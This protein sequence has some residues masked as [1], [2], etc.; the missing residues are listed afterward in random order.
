ML[1]FLDVLF[2]LVHLII[3]GFNLLGW[4]WPVTRKTH[5]IC[6]LTTVVS[7]F[8]LG[9]WFGMGYCPVTDWQWNVK[10]KLGEINLPAS[11]VKYYADKLFQKNFSS[12]VIDTL[13]VVLFTISALFA[14]YFN[15]IYK[16][17]KIKKS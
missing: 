6:V 10:T 16:K 2:T 12:S 5:L 3:I 17:I 1:Q 11:F 7:W 9:I 15:F 4:I 14:V 13:T 8:L